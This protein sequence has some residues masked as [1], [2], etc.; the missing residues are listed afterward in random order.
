MPTAPINY[1]ANGTSPVLDKPSSTDLLMAAAELEQR[2]KAAAPGSV[3]KSNKRPKKLRV[4][5]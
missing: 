1:S 5:K 3:P 2:R 4:V